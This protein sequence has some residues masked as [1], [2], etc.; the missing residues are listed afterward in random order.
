L[1]NSSIGLLP[2]ASLLLVG[3]G[4]WL[5]SLLNSC[6]AAPP[7]GRQMATAK[8]EYREQNWSWYA[9]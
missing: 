1:A 6:H 9:L 5:A 3:T 7:V 4:A 2:K 8:S